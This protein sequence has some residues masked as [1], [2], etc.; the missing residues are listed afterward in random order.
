MEK[1]H[2]NGDRAEKKKKKRDVHELVFAGKSSSFPLMTLD[3]GFFF[4]PN[5]TL[6]HLSSLYNIGK[7][8]RME[9]GIC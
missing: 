4:L 8:W 3:P 5:W 2:P 6:K 7:L 9:K 1:A